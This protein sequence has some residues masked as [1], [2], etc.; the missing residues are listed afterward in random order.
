MI[1]CN[2]MEIISFGTVV[3]ASDKLGNLIIQNLR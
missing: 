3:K 1:E 2:K